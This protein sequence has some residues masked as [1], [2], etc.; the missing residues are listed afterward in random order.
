[1]PLNRSQAPIA[2][3]LKALRLP[4]FEVVHLNNGIP[5][6]LLPYGKAEVLQL[7]W[8]FKAGSNFLAQ[9]GLASFTLRNLQEG[10]QNRSAIEIA[11]ELDQYGAWIGHDVGNE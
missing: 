9:P 5:L 11:Q 1:M 6:Y 2:S 4:D 10:T 3:P 8:I 7:Q